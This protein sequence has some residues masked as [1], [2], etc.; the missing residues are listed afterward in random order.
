MNKEIFA[1]VDCNNFYVS[2]E[3][4]FNPRLRARPVVV[5][6]NNDGCVVARSNQAK[7]LG[8]GMGVPAFKVRDILTKNKVEALSSNYTLYDDM[9]S[10]VMQALSNFTPKI[11]IYSIDEAFLDLAGFNCDL[12]D[13]GRKIKQTTEKWTGIP[14]TVGIGRTK[15]LAKIAGRIAKKSARAKGVLDL[16]DSPHLEKALS[17][18]PVEKIWGV[19]IRT[20]I[21]LKRI[22]IDTALDLKNTDVTQIRT[23][24]GVVGVRTVYELRGMPCYALQ[25]NPPANK[26]VCVSRM[27][28]RPVESLE[29][30]KQ[31][32]SSYSARAGEKLRQQE[33]AAHSMTVFLTTSRFINNKYF[34]SCTIEFD[35]AT[36]DTRQLIRTACRCIEKLHRRNREF[37]K[38]GV[39]L[40]NLIPQ[41]H[42]QTDLLEDINPARSAKLMKTID[43]INA[44]FNCPVRWAA[45]GLNQPWR[46]KFNRRSQRFTTCWNELLTV[47]A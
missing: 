32:V 24:L 12:T 5:L 42:I 30:L 25:D 13:Y 18:V 22:G 23:M 40:N 39:V 31:A 27:F 28:G 21:K 19:G 7:A 8:I 34:N 3:R 14:V 35:T 45:E 20:A 29:E 46:T 43:K 44:R 9:S 38:C 33:L 10:R 15:T 4:V 36:S 37:Q 6:S 1:L 11:E 41:A 17:M 47:T 2:C 16:T 26:S